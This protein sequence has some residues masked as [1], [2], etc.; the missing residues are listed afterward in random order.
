MRL[1]KLLI[2]GILLAFALT[3]SSQVLGSELKIGVLAKRGAENCL[4]Q[5]V[6]TAQYLSSVTGHEVRI[7]PLRFE[8]AD[9]MVANK[10]VDFIIVNSSMYCDIAKKHGA[11]AIATLENSRQGQ[12][13]TEFGGVLFTKADSPIE[14][15]EDIRGKSFMCVKKNSFGGYQM[16]LM[17]LQEHG[18]NPET[19]CSLFKEAGTH[20]QVVDMVKKGVIQVGCVRTDTIERMAA[21]GK[22]SLSDFKIINKQSGN[23]PFVYSTELYP[24]WPC[25]SCAHT[26]KSVVDAVAKALV[27]MPKDSDAAKAAKCVGWVKP[28]NYEPVIHLLATLKLG[29][30]AS[31]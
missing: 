2:G 25:A 20:D 15:L 17:L 21:E 24:E 3:L 5:W 29:T 12:A 28:L 13:L 18:I 19:D 1:K 4:K 27:D 7:V 9:Q 23:F 31:N 30:F 26:D 10:Q 8:V 11:E 14:T 16:Q 6:P 22:C